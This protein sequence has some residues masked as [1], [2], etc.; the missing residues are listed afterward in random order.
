[1]QTYVTTNSTYVNRQ[2]SPQKVVFLPG[3]EQLVGTFSFCLFILVMFALFCFEGA[4]K[5]RDSS[6]RIRRD[7]LL[8]SR[9]AVVGFAS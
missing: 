4:S 8:S 2:T 7:F 6:S 5:S 3:K 1:M 9:V